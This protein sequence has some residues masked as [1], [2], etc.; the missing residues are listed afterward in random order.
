MTA[1]GSANIDLCAILCED[2]KNSHF[3]VCSECGLLCHTR[4]FGSLEGLDY[5]ILH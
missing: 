4:T 5:F 2:F 1:K 3:I